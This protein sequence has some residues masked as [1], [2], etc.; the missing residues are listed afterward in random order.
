MLYA[1]E[2][3]ELL[4]FCSKD[5]PPP[6]QREITRTWWMAKPPCGRRSYIATTLVLSVKNA[7]CGSFISSSLSVA[8]GFSTDGLKSA[9][10][11]ERNCT[12]GFGETR[13]ENDKL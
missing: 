8:K 3:A 2:T 4:M 12:V 11:M 13:G 7:P 1:G 9:P 5:L 10:K 6:S